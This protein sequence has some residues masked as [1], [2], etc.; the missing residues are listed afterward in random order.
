[1]TKIVVYWGTILRSISNSGAIMQV[2]RD[3]SITR[4]HGSPYMARPRPF[5]RAHKRE[6]SGGLLGTKYSPQSKLEKDARKGQSEFL[7]TRQ[8]Q[9]RASVSFSICYSNSNNDN[10]ITYTP[11]SFD[12]CDRNVSISKVYL[13]VYI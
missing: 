8:N 6:A 3:E 10:M 9:N 12:F 13:H 1:M 7:F 4:L 5:P 11:K 2:S